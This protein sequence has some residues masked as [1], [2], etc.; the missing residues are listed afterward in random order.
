MSITSFALSLNMYHATKLTPGAVSSLLFVTLLVSDDSCYWSGF[1]L[2][3]NISF[4]KCI[5]YN[6][7]HIYSMYSWALGGLI[8]IMCYALTRPKTTVYNVTINPRVSPDYVLNSHIWNRERLTSAQEI[9]IY[10]AETR[11]NDTTTAPVDDTSDIRNMTLLPTDNK[12]K[13]NN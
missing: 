9:P 6:T 12:L 3:R 2:H 5:E 4:Y 13:K 1:N 10:A 8:S 7:V 11:L